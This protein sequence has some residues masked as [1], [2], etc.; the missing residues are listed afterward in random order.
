MPL[1][2]RSKP[3]V[4]LVSCSILENA[5]LSRAPWNE[6]AAKASAMTEKIIAR[7]RLNGLN[8]GPGMCDLVHLATPT[9]P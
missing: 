6:S 8:A 2:T 1:E 4:S 5:R 9:S 7:L 3:N